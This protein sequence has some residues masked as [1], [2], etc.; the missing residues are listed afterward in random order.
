MVDFEMWWIKNEA[1]CNGQPMDSLTMD[2][3]VARQWTA[4]DGLDGTALPWTACNGQ[5]RVRWTAWTGLAMDGLQWIGWDGSAMDWMAMDG[6]GSMDSS[7]WIEWDGTTM[8]S[9]RWTLYHI[10]LY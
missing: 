4:H 8:D 1:R 2:G 7:Q 5:A 9:L 6:N 3:L 10:E